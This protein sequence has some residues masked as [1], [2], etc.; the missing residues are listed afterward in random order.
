MVADQLNLAKSW[1]PPVVHRQKRAAG[2]VLSGLFGIV[3]IGSSLINHY[4]ISQVWTNVEQNQKN[5]KELVWE[6]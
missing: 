6:K 5:I 1:F 2:A 3:G 4:R